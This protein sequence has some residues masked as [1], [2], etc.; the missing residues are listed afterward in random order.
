MIGGYSFEE[1]QFNRATCRR[2]ARWALLQ[3][4]RVRGCTGKRRD[5]R[6]TRL[7]TRR[8]P[9][10]SGAA[11]L[12]AQLRENLE[13]NITLRGPRRVAQRSPP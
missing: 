5:A 11:L 3:S 6:S 13:G 7:W 10:I 9:P 4:L 1:F 12:S 8:L 2:F